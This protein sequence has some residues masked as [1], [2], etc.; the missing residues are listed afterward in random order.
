MGDPLQSSTCRGPTHSTFQMARPHSNSTIPRGSR[1]RWHDHRGVSRVRPPPLGQNPWI[2]PGRHLSTLTGPA[3]GDPQGYGWNPPS[4]DSHCTRP[5]D[6]TSHCTS[7]CAHLRSGFLGSQLWIPSRT[8]GTG[9][10]QKGQ[11]V[12]PYYWMNY[13]GI[14]EYYRPIPEIDHPAQSPGSSTGLEE[15]AHVLLETV[16]L[17]AHQGARAPEAGHVS[18]AGH[19]R[20]D[21]PQRPV[22]SG[23]DSGHSDW[24]DPAKGGTQGSRVFAEASPPQE[25]FCLS[26]SCGLAL[27]NR[28]PFGKFNRVNTC[29]P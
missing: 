23:P 12:Y 6:P 19:L 13:F 3:G 7:P 2:F 15:G 24:Y 10:G 27:L 5:G 11:R 1:Y 26:K 25:V 17:C 14:S 4:G 22:A 20:G 21:Q 9:R 8:L 18:E 16:A 29:P 28:V